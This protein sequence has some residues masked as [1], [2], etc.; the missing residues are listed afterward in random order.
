MVQ[1]G[2]FHIG[3]AQNAKQPTVDIQAAAYLWD[4]LVGRYLCLEETR[5]YLNLVKDQ[6]FATILQTGI[7]VV[8]SKQIAKIEQ[9]MEK[10]RLPL[11]Q[12][13][14]QSYKHL[15]EQEVE[16]SDEYMFRQIFEGCQKYMDYLACICRSLIFNDSLR[17]IFNDFLKSELFFFDKMCLYGKSK[18]WL[19][20]PP[21][22]KH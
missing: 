21:M 14:P 20:P 7:V 17:E 13:S 12:R 1:I 8:L 2:D 16:I 22:Y 10:Y 9:E 6:E 11:P 15:L 5:I 4:F 3:K 18:G 19:E